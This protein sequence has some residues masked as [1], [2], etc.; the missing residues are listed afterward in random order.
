MA[1][2]PLLSDIGQT[3]ASRIETRRF[4]FSHYMGKDTEAESIK[5]ELEEEKDF[6]VVCGYGRIGKV[7]ALRWHVCLLF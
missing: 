1:A 7:G 2:T 3:L 4:G 5:K 6:V